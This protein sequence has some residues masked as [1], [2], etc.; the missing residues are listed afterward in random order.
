[1]QKTIVAQNRDHLK[2]LIADEIEKYGNECDLN[3]IDVS[4]IEDMSSLFEKSDFNGNISKWNVSKVESMSYMFKNSQFNG[5]ISKWN[6][7]KVRAMIRMFSKSQFN[8]DIS[9]WNVSNVKI[10]DFMFIESKINQNLNVWTPFSLIH[11][12]TIFNE[13]YPLIPYWANLETNEDIHKAINSY[14]LHGKLNKDLKDRN[15]LI[16]QI[17]I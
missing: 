13:S 10:M 7:S 5:D 8:G 14:Q 4:N 12:L 6:T 11:S 16:K 1:M 9:Q 15:S 3:H 17:K 2:Q